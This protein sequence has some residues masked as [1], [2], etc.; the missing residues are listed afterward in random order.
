MNPYGKKFAEF[1]DKRFGV[2]ADKS[3][4]GLLRF[5]SSRPA[6]GSFSRVLDLGC[7][8]GQLAFHFL[9]AGYSFTGV[10]FSPE[11]LLLARER[12]RRHWVGGKA[13]F[14]EADISDFEIPGPFG[15]VVSTYN[16]LNHLE[17]EGALRGCFRSAKKSLA[18][19][20]VFLFDYHTEL[21]LTAWVGNES[22]SE[23]GDSVQSRGEFNASTGKAVMRLEITVKGE[24]FQSVIENQTFPLRRIEEWLLEEGFLEVRFAE[25]TKLDQTLSDPG[26]EKRVVVI[27]T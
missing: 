17:T 12:C 20:G 10:D 9:E 6:A 15:M 7:G 18:P 23:E 25:M 2:Y 4:P 14:I 24:V 5:F 11:M 8:T 19:G 1:Y 22:S 27:A 26:M 13:E 21:G 3:A 16:S